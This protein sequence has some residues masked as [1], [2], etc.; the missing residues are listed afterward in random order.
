MFVAG[1]QIMITRDGAPCT[2]NRGDPC[3]EASEFPHDV[4]MR[5]LK[6][7]TLVNVDKA[8]GAGTALQQALTVQQRK[9]K[10]SPGV[11]PAPVAVAAAP[12]PHEKPAPAAAKPRSTSEVNNGPRKQGRSSTTL[13]KEK[14]AKKKS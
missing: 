2:L 3:P 9:L 1:Q 14:A 7:G 5:L 10:E 6:V 8:A 12:A 13:N 4:L 11:L